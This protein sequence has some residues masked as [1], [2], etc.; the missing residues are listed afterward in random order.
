MSKDQELPEEEDTVRGDEPAVE[1][2][3]TEPENEDSAPKGD[4]SEDNKSEDDEPENDESGDDESEDDES[5]ESEDDES[6]DGESADD[7]PEDKESEDDESEDDESEDD[8]SEDDESEDDESAED[9]ESALPI[10]SIVEALLIGSSEPQT[11]KTLARG[12]RKGTKVAVVKEAIAE[13]NKFYLE[14]ERSFEIVQV[15][16]YY[17]IMTLP[18]FA[19]H[20]NPS[21]DK[22]AEAKKLSPAALDTLAIV[23]YRQP[24]MRVEIERIRGVGCG[25]VLRSLMELGLTRVVGKNTEILGH[26]SLYGTTERFLE[27]FGLGSLDELPNVEQLRA[28]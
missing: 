8:E 17:Q 19:H 4:E 6:E 23:A 1:E 27:V 2:E 7:E 26:P 25:P 14:S 20:L 22:G 18:D 13:L 10:P 5:D 16:D 11:A 12:V 9:E 28:P 3:V 15:G 21:A 24:L